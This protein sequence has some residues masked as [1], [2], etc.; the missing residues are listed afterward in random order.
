MGKEGFENETLGIFKTDL[1]FVKYKLQ[2]DSSIG[3]QKIFVKENFRKREIFHPRNYRRLTISILLTIFVIKNTPV[4][5]ETQRSYQSTIYKFASSVSEKTGEIEWQPKGNFAAGEGARTKF[6]IRD[7]CDRRKETESAGQRSGSGGAAR[8][9]RS[10]RFRGEA[11]V[12][13]RSVH[14][15][16]IDSRFLLSPF[17]PLFFRS[18]A[19]GRSST[20]LLTRPVFLPVIATRVLGVVLACFAIRIALS[21]SERNGNRLRSRTRRYSLYVHAWHT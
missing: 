20:E 9:K 15:Q 8:K 13:G 21:P 7:S 17:L 5:I 16:P 18:A 14:V 4:P 12:Q 2:K 11:I 10:G 1:S 19:A 6:G 3:K